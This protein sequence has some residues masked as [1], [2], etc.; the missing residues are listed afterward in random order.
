MQAIRVLLADDH[1]LLSEG[2]RYL[3]EAES[4][5]E[6]V[7][8]CGNGRQAV[9]LAGELK[10]DVVLMDITMPELNGIE[11]TE[12]IL[13]RIPGLKVVILSMYSNPE[14]IQ[15][16]LHAGAK[17]YLVKMS[18]GKEVVDAVRAVHKGGCY[19]SARV[20]EVVVE[21]YS[22]T[23]RAET[24]TPLE[25]LS[26]R[27]RQVLQL[28]VEGTTTQEIARSLSLSPRTVETYRTRLMEKLGIGDVPTLVKFAI[29][30][31]LTPLE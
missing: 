8:A 9:R 24:Q 6:V 25:R 16:A 21:D 29:Q 1:E 31:G 7:G 11:A 23:G 18:A 14:H 19:L 5:I 22:R 4:D 27:E 13:S 2:L 15:R 30:H 10:P 28:V 20:A 26:A 17:G 3:L 12:L